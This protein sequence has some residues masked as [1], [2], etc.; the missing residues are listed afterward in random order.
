MTQA[1]L[2]FQAVQYGFAAYIRDPVH[3]PVP[4]GV[5]TERM[6]MYRELFFNNIE[7]FLATGFPVLKSLLEPGQWLA[8]V[9]GFFARHRNHTPLFVGIPEEFLDY[10]ARERSPS[11]QD[12]PFLLE[13]AHY[14]WVELVLEVA[15]H[16]PPALD[17][18]LLQNP[19]SRIVRLS[20]LAWPL[21]YR[22]P[23]HKLGPHYQ[24]AEPPP[25]PT[26]LLVYRN[27]ED[28]IKFLE[29]NP[30]T[31]RLLERLENEEPYPLQDHLQHMARELG[32]TDT[33]PIIGFGCDLIRDWAER[34]IVGLT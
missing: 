26:C 32:Q 25:D 24:P 14:E 18:A 11:P 23:V 27:R 2:P 6:A 21:I 17:P 5:A 9:Q 34:G 29:V 7:N 13:L 12:P 20:E 28:R 30:V 33:A 1:R 10:L 19:G 3:H 31:Y 22:F 16:E 15:E 4:T 8:L